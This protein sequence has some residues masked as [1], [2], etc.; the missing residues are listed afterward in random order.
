MTRKWSWMSLVYIVIMVVM[1]GC[2]PRSAFIGAPLSGTA[3]L[4]VN[5]RDTSYSGNG[6]I[7]EWLWSFGDGTSSSDQN[8]VHTYTGAGEF[9]VTLTVTAGDATATYTDYVYIEDCGDLAVFLGSDLSKRM[10]GEVIYID[11]GF[12]IMGVQIAAKEEKGE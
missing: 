3:P 1:S 2:S 7:T 12:N 8:P 9:W 11:A 6:Q 5:F 4:T 10:T